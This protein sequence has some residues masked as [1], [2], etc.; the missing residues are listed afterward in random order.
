RLASLAAMTREG[1][2]SRSLLNE[3][4]ADSLQRMQDLSLMLKNISEKE[5]SNTAL[6][7]ADYEL[8]RSFGVH[9]EHFWIEALRD[10]INGNIAKMWDNPAGL[11]ADVA[12]DPNGMVLE[13]ATG[14]VQQIF[15]VVPLDGKLRIVRGAVYSYYEFPWPSSDRLTDEKWK[16]MLS[17][18]QTPALPGW[19]A[20]FTAQKA[21][22]AGSN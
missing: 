11:I 15:A 6:A 18:Q 19:T 5:L 22:H 10:K 4:D 3:R 20:T 14:Y 9:L 1:L 17:R 8:I 16:E 2:Q 13:E 7:E 12:T 21:N